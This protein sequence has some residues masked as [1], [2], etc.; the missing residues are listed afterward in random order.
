M[1][2]Y[3]WHHDRSWSRQRIWE[4]ENSQCIATECLLWWKSEIDSVKV[5]GGRQNAVAVCHQV[6][7]VRYYT[8]SNIWSAFWIYWLSG[9]DKICAV[10]RMFLS[11]RPLT[12]AHHRSMRYPWSCNVLVSRRPWN[13]CGNVGEHLSCWLEHRRQLKQHSWI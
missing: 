7:P 5:H 8:L 10:N 6:N 2:Y 12:T 9:R 1:L 11:D 4:V 3:I 13:P